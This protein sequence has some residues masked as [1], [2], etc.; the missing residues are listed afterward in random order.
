MEHYLQHCQATHRWRQWI[1]DRDDLEVLPLTPDLLRDY[2]PEVLLLID[3]SALGS[4]AFQLELGQH[5]PHPMRRFWSVQRRPLDYP[6][7]WDLT[8]YRDPV[9]TPPDPRAGPHTERVDLQQWVVPDQSF[10]KKRRLP[11]LTW[12]QHSRP[13]LP[14]NPLA[15]ALPAVPA[16]PFR[17]PHRAR[18]RARLLGRPPPPMF[19]WHP[20]GR[21]PDRGSPSA[22]QRSSSPDLL[23]YSDW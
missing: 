1:I 8:P 6:H 4:R 11:A 12:A 22:G 5:L 13:R 10:G 14:A 15:T 17:S 23:T 21:P 18:V 7:T 16:T 2:L 19:I 20:P 9:T 3:H